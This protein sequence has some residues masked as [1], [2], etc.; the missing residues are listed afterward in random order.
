MKHVAEALYE[1]KQTRT[2]KWREHL[3]HT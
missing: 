1:R 3:L 2:L